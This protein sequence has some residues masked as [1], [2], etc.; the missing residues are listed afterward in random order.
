MNNIGLLI[1]LSRIQQNMKQVTLAKGICSTSYLSKI[2]NNQTVPSED[3]LQLLLER[4]HL[5]YEDLSTEQEVKF[6]SDLYALYKEAII[7]RN[8]EEIVKHLAYYTERNFLFKDEQ[9]FYTYKLYLLRL[10]LITDPSGDLCQSLIIALSQMEDNFDKK[11]TFLFNLNKGLYYYLEKDFSTSLQSFEVSLSLITN[12]HLEDWEL[13][14]F[15][16]TIS[17]SYLSH[18]YILNTIEYATKSLNIYKDILVFSRAIDCYLVIGIANNRNSN[19]KNAEESFLLAKKLIKDLK[20]YKHN[21]IVNHNLGSLFA[22]QGQSEKAIEYYKESLKNSEDTYDYLLTVLSIII[23]YSKLNKVEE[24]LVWCE[25]GISL[26]TSE[27]SPDY[28]SFLYH[29]QIYQHLNNH[30]SEI[31]MILINSIKHFELIK[32]YNYAYKYSI[33]L[34]DYYAKNRKYKNSVIYLQK[35]NSFLYLIK[36]INHWEDL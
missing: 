22:I 3:V 25:K 27:S 9:N 15:Y 7:E 26:V 24:L 1:K 5:D 32:E 10:Y 23:E 21:S 18:N 11:Q 13:A 36:N 33:V 35:A 8:K 4:L 28:Q 34:G 12:F 20:L 31:E 16:Y 30:D 6:L 2:E 29:F 14:D 19:F 17:V